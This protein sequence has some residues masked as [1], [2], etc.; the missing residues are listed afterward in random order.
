MGREGQ[1][2]PSVGRIHHRFGTPFA[3]ILLSAVVMLAS[4]TLPTQSAGN[5]SSLF[6][7]LS[8]II[9]NAAVVRL[10]RERPNMTRPYEVP[11]YPIPPLLGIA[12]NSLLTVVLIVFILQTD[13]L[14]LLL[15]V[16]WIAVGV[17]IYQLVIR[18]PGTDDP[19]ETA[20][21]TTGPGGDD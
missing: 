11:Y 19:V 21:T 14:A 20:E 4:T 16:G 7:L 8:F 12:L 15:S 9:V 10:R 18:S 1:L 3:A 17:A 2:L 5:M 13:P 6:F